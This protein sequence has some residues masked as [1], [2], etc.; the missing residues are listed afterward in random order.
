MDIINFLQSFQTDWLTSFFKFI[1][2]FGNEEFYILVLPLLF[3]FWD[4]DKALKLMLILLPSLMLNAYLKEVFQTARPVGVALIEQD[5]FAFP[6]GH[7][8]GTATLWLMLALLLRQKWMS[9]LAAAMLILVPLSRLYLGV[10]WPADV[11]GGLAIGALVV[12]LYWA[13]LY[14]SLGKYLAEKTVLSQAA[15]LTTVILFFACLFPAPDAIPVLAVIW[16]FGLIVIFS[17]VVHSKPRDGIIWIIITLVVGIIGTLLIWKGLKVVLPYNTIGRF[18][19]YAVLGFWIAYL[20]LLF[21]ER[22]KV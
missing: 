3:W 17:D 11:L 4:K 5:G 22:E 6:S 13:F 14:E 16:G 12:W 9:I 15:L 21:R 19:R 7:A 2:F 10:H 20:P 1:T 18:I 8:Q